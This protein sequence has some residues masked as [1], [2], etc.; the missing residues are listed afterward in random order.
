MQIRNQ[1][2]TYDK[3]IFYSNQFKYVYNV[4]ELDYIYSIPTKAK[5]KNSFSLKLEKVSITFILFNLTY[6]KVCCF[7]YLTKTNTSDFVITESSSFRF[8]SR[9]LARFHLWRRRIAY[10]AFPLRKLLRFS[11]PQRKVS[12]FTSSRKSNMFRFYSGS[13]KYCHIFF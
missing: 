12:R 11:S 1:T 13:G 2:T 7:I 4:N 5:Q 8:W 10:C 6:R 9:K 3:R